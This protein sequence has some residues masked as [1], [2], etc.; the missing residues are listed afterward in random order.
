MSTNVLNPPASTS[1]NSATQAANATGKDSVWTSGWASVDGW[2]SSGPNLTQA[3][4]AL[5]TSFQFFKFTAP[6]FKEGVQQRHNMYPGMNEAQQKSL[7]TV[8]HAY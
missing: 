6:Q 4:D 1:G 8:L 3:F 5:W 7:R 2:K